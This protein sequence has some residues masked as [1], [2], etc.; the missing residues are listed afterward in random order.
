MKTN[1]FRSILAIVTGV[2]I[3]VMTIGL[4][5]YV[6][7]WPETHVVLLESMLTIAFLCALWMYALPKV[8]PMTEKMLELKNE[9]AGKYLRKIRR[10]SYIVLVSIAVCAIGVIFKMYHVSGGAEMLMCGGFTIAFY[11]IIAP[12]Y[13]S[14]Y[15]N[16]LK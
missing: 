6:L 7:H 14:K 3:S 1:Q 11:G 10:V 12:F 13:Y 5:F 15:I 16:S 9:N 2:G 4:L 8:S